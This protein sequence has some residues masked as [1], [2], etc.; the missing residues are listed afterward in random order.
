MRI[1]NLKEITIKPAGDSAVQIFCGREISEAVGD[2]V[3]ALTAALRDFFAKENVSGA[4]EVIPAFSSLIVRYDPLVTDYEEMAFRIGKAA[5]DLQ[6]AVAGE[7]HRRVVEIPVCYGGEFGEDLADVAAHNNLTEQEV[8]DIHSGGLYRLYMIGFLPGFPYLGG[9]DKR[10]CCPR[11]KSPRTKIPAGAVGIGGE[12]TGIYPMESPGGWRLIGRTPLT[13]FDPE[14]IV[15]LPYKA[16]DMIKF[17]AIHRTEYE[18]IAAAEAQ[19]KE[20]LRRDK[21]KEAER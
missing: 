20:K 12:Q 13:L 1:T 6:L 11:L 3:S 4:G 7:S 17:V 10:I 15:P 19:R 14:G 2:K 5:A 21:G 18:K 9:L 16:G 8:V